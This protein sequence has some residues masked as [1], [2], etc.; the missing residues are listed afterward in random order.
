MAA[1]TIPLENRENVLVESDRFGFLRC[2]G[3]FG[4]ACCGKRNG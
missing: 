2:R 1:L 3:V 4:H